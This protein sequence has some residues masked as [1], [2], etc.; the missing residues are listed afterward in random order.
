MQRASAAPPRDLLVGPLRF[1]QGVFR[2][3]LD[4]NASSD[5]AAIHGA[6]AGEIAGLAWR[7]ASGED[8]ARL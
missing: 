3:A 1:R 4:G 2:R 5:A 6:R 7:I 8:D